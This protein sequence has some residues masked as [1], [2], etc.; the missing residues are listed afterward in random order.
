MPQLGVK[1][2]PL[3]AIEGTPPNLFRQVA[4]DA[5]APRNPQALK[6]DFVRR[7]P[8]FAVTPTHAARTWL[9]DPRAP[10]VEPPAH[11]RALREKGRAAACGR[12]VP[13][14]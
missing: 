11:I 8:M 6:I 10:R 14:V 7:P 9:L 3:Y 12:E 5:F 2:E 1:G 4:G 13:H